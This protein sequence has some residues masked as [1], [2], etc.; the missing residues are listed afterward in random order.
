MLQ[1]TNAPNPE[2]ED[3][4]NYV[5]KYIKKLQDGI[6]Q[7]Y[8]TIADTT[9]E[10]VDELDEANAKIAGVFGQ[11]QKSVVGLRQEIAVALPSLV[12]MGGDSR[13]A[14]A[15]QE[16]VAKSLQTNVITTVYG[17]RLKYLS[18]MS[19]TKKTH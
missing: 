1:P 17:V 3:R 14:I 4:L 18:L 8:K 19:L 5:A 13:D 10:L 12:R 2:E 11:T 7:A 6:N 9:N 16:S 15:I